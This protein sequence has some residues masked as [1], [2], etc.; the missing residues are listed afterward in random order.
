MYYPTLEECRKLRWPGGTLP[1]CREIPAGI[2]T[3][4]SV[5][6]KVHRGGYGFLL[7]SVPGGERLARY[8]YI[9]TEPYRVAATREGDVAGPLELLSEEMQRSRPVSVAGLPDFD[10]GAV[11][12]LGY[13][14]ARRFEALPAP[15][16]DTLGL[17]ESLLMFTDTFI[18]FD[19]LTHSLKVI[20]RLRR[21]GDTDSGYQE[22]TRRIDGLVA[23]LRQAQEFTPRPSGPAGNNGQAAS[24]NLTQSEYENGVRQAKDFIAAGEAIQVVLSRRLSR[25]T[26]ARPFSIYRAL[27]AINPSPY[28]YYLDLKDFHVMGTSPE[29][30]VKVQDGVVTTRPLAGTR[31]RGDNPAEDARLEQELRSDEKERAEHVMLVDLGRN[32]IGRVSVPGTVA[33]S[34]LMQVERY[35]HVMHLVTNVAGR[36]RPELT[37]LDALR[38]C[39]PAGTVSGAPKIRAMEIIAGLEPYKRGPY[40]GCVGYFGFSGNMDTAIT[41]RTI[42]MK[43][44]IAYVQAGAGIVYDS[45]SEREYAETGNKARAMLQAIEDAEALEKE[46]R[47]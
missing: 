5:F 35:S 10:G 24:G 12:Y 47:P 44:G 46:A 7:E 25:P 39:F 38:A 17:P 16:A 2:D 23:R 6:L 21:E 18:A 45:V 28:M 14:T 22:A 20:S 27:R 31:P 19:H 9:G 41:I 30:L 32:D 33:V 34:D 42:V 26:G 43:E 4:L 15:A 13:E 29:I 3:P 8:S 36:L 11:G 37:A 40:A 1:V